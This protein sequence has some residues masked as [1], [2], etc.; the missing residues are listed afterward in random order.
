MAK[1]TMF[2]N[3][4][5]A[6]KYFKEMIIEEYGEKEWKSWSNTTRRC[7][8]IDWIDSLHKDGQLCDSQRNY[9]WLYK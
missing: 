5:Q 3:N 4:A 9:I 7:V 8:F 6:C 1:K 2:R